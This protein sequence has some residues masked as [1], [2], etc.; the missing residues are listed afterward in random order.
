MRQ[1][2]QE[3][4]SNKMASRPRDNLDKVKLQSQGDD[5]AFENYLTKDFYKEKA[6]NKVLVYEKI[7]NKLKTNEN[8]RKEISDYY[9]MNN[10]LVHNFL[11]PA[12]K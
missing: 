4:V 6:F 12:K 1:R 2:L 9:Q 11:K 7:R 3:F 8:G 5:F 10:Q